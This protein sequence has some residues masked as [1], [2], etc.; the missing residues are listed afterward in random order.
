MEGLLDR[1]VNSNVKVSAKQN[2]ESLSDRIHFLGTIRRDC[3]GGPSQPAELHPLPIDK[4]RFIL[5]AAAMRRNRTTRRSTLR[6]PA[7]FRSIGFAII[8]CT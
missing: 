3:A 8:D 4:K 1:G 7:G 2:V 6:V 5:I